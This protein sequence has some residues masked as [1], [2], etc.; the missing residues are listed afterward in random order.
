MKSSLLQQ[1]QRVG[2]S[3]TSTK[4]TIGIHP[5][6]L[7]YGSEIPEGETWFHQLNLSD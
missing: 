2:R 4:V 3:F 7:L 5:E 6:T 1:Q